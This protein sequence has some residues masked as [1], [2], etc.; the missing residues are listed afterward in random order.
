MET[1]IPALLI[2]CSGR[3]PGFLLA[4]TLLLE[5]GAAACRITIRDR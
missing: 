5:A 2:G 1:G 4:I 3:M